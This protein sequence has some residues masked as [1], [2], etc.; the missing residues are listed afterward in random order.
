MPLKHKQTKS[1]K[2][3]F[4]NGSLV[5]GQHIA[6]DKPLAKRLSRVLRLRR[7][8][9]IALFN[10]IDGLLKAE[11]QD[12]NTTTAYLTEVLC[13][14]PQAA[15]VWLLIALT[16]KDAMDRV[17]RQATEFGVTHIVPVKTDF[18]VADK[19]NPERINAMLVEAAEQSE[20]LNVPQLMDVHTL[21]GALDATPGHVYWCDESTGGK[22]VGNPKSGDGLLIGPEGGFSL[23][24]RSKLTQSAK[25]SPTG[26]GPHILRVDTAVCAACSR[27]FDHMS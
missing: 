25:V 23:S 1:L 21:Q 15:D 26:L 20:R 12:D 27:F 17:F 16:K 5:A 10:G 3:L 9:C 18:T 22:W 8:E 11:L 4:Y 19:I 14:Q 7:G 2:Q 24:E 6:L 13:P